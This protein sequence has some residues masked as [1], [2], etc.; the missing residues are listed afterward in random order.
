MQENSLCPLPHP[1][2]PPSQ[3]V[4]YLVK[5]FRPYFCQWSLRMSSTLCLR[6]AR[7]ESQARTAQR[8]SF[9]RM[10]SEPGRGRAK[11]CEKHDFSKILGNKLNSKH[12]DPAKEKLK[13]HWK[14]WVH[15]RNHILN[16]DTWYWKEVDASQSNFK[17]LRQMSIKMSVE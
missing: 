1:T 2:S 11:S 17:N 6:V 12:V 3:A 16:K 14:T 5:K 13:L 10:W 7:M 4:A 8:P 15:G 9:S